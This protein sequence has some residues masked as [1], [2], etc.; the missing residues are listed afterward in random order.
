MTYDLIIGF[1][2]ACS[3][4]QSLRK[5]ELQFLSFPFD[6]VVPDNDHFEGDLPRRADIVC[7]EFAD[8]LNAEDLEYRGPHINGMDH[9]LNRRW[10]F[11][12]LHD[13]PQGVPLEE[14]LP[15]VAGK[16]HRRTARMLELIR[17]SRRVLVVRLDRPDRKHSTP[18]SDCRLARQA[19][20]RKFPG[21]AFDFVLI[22]QDECV[23]DETPEEG[24]RLL[25]FDYLNRTPGADR[26]Q[27]VF[28]AV[29]NALKSRFRVRD[30]RTADERR[31]WKRAK[32]LKRYAKL[33]AA[34]AL[35]YRWRKLLSL[36]LPPSCAAR[37]SAP[38]PCTS[39]PDP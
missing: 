15:S 19:L 23:R 7:A 22:Q 20:M 37:P 38:A 10:G 11:V 29:V 8:W 35:Q 27:P 13:F 24:V 36:I 3:C 34:N 16:Y 30:Y 25:S 2:M 17:R 26:S 28:S 12:H 5:A 9:Y 18:V 1:G 39:S 32:R 6:W 21:T 33:G 14:S 4:S 31:Q